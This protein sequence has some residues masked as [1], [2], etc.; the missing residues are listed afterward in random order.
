MPELDGLLQGEITSAA[1]SE[2]SERRCATVPPNRTTV[3]LYGYL[4]TDHRQACGAVGGVIHCSEGL[5]TVRG[6]DDRIGY[7]AGRAAV[8][9][10][11]IVS[12]GDGLSQ[13]AAATDRNGGRKRR[14]LA[15]GHEKRYAGKRAFPLSL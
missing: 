2:D 15:E 1:D 10:D 9:G 13:G 8:E 3:T 12:C 4:T 7:T 11:I 6:Q 14:P 5:S